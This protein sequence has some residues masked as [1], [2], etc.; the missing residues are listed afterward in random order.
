V[1]APQAAD[2]GGALKPQRLRSGD[3][4]GIVSPSWY[5]PYTAHR[6]ERGSEHMR[7]LGFEVKVAPHALNRI[8]GWLSDT[9]EN[10]AADIHAM[11]SDPE[12]GA[13]VASIGGDHSCQLLP[14]LDWDLLRSN[15]KIFMGYSDITVLNVAIWKMAGLGT[16]SGPTL[17]TEWAEYPRMPEYTERYVLKGAVRTRAGGGDRT[18]RVVDG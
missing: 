18:G 1:S 16:F 9:P 13:V 6:V 10:R 3:T 2:L 4:I 15:P 5:D 8:D 11:F 7:S 12:I 14:H 17:I